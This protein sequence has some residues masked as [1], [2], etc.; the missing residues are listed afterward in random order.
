M[1]FGVGSVTWRST[2]MNISASSRIFHDM[3]DMVHT[4][5]RFPLAYACAP[6]KNIWVTMLLIF[7]CTHSVD[8]HLIPQLNRIYMESARSWN[9]S[10]VNHFP[11][12]K[13]SFGSK[14]LSGTLQECMVASTVLVTR[15]GKKK[16]DKNHG[17]VAGF[18]PQQN[19]LKIHILFG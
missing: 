3:A 10:P 7:F 16:S 19:K 15:F 9:D 17:S 8:L 4:N 13:F 18:A 14:E 12:P 6:K 2:A 1:R 11:P 5:T